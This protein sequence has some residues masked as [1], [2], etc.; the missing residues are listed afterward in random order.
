MNT[1]DAI[2]SYFGADDGPRWQPMPDK[3]W[4]DELVAA[5]LA[6]APRSIVDAGCGENRFKH[7]L[8]GLLGIDI[9]NPAA[10]MVCDVVDAPIA[11]GR[12][13]VVLALGSVNF[14]DRGTIAAQLTCIH[15]WL[16]PGGSLFMRVNPGIPYPDCPSLVIYPW[17]VA[18]VHE[19]AESIGF[20]VA[21]PPRTIT[22]RDGT[23]QRPRLYWRYEKS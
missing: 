6:L 10:D 9:G 14:G 22:L 20:R 18:D 3:H 5:V 7:R 2:L 21:S 16:R 15:R 4:D 12:I 11:E 19:F 17:S 8:P 1:T 23:A 13:D